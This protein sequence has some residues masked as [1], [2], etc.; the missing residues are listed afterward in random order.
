MAWVDVE[1]DGDSW[2]LI[3][4]IVGVAFGGAAWWYRDLVSGLFAYLGIGFALILA[5]QFWSQVR[6]PIE[7]RR[8]A[9]VVLKW[10][11]ERCPKE[12]IEPE[13][14]WWPRGLM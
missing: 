13:S 14:D 6:L 1:E 4:G 11:R 9:N 8:A 12:R 7:A 10:F 5:K 3:A 2:V